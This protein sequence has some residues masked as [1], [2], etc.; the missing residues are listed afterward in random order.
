MSPTHR[1]PGYIPGMQRPMTPHEILESKEHFSTILQATTS[2]P[3]PGGYHDGA[4]DAANHPTHGRHGSENSQNDSISSFIE[5]H[6][7]NFLS[8]SPKSNVNKTIARSVDSPALPESL[9]IESQHSNAR[10]Y[11]PG[12]EEGAGDHERAPSVISGKDPGPLLP[13]PRMSRSPTPDGNV[14]PTTTAARTANHRGNVGNRAISPSFSLDRSNNMSAPMTM[15]VG[16]HQNTNPSHSSYFLLSTSRDF[17][18]SPRPRIRAAPHLGLKGR[19][20]IR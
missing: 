9:H 3:F 6:N 14:L 7:P 20:I 17:L 4:V 18:F 15:K 11:S 10:C 19:V 13:F 2:R 1:V 5:V 8:T 12:G 16:E